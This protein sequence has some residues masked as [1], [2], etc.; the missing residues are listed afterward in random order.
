MPP[1]LG[2]SRITTNRDSLYFHSAILITFDIAPKSE[3]RL[4]EAIVYT[5]HGIN[6]DDLKMLAMASP[7]I[8]TLALLHGLH[9]IKLSVRQLNLG[10]HNALRAQRISG[11]R[12][13]V[14]THDEIKKAGGLVSR[15]LKRKI[16]TIEDVLQ[17]EKKEAGGVAIE[18]PLAALRDIHFA[19]LDSGESLL[20]E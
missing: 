14:S 12:Y 4:G 10:A 20:L 16:W 7:R 9:D 6:A 13:W 18:D 8:S 17:E 5:P 15:F 11:S 19:N 2:I 1:W 3:D